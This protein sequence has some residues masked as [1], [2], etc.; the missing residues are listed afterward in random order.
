MQPVVPAPSV[1]SEPLPTLP[2]RSR[3]EAFTQALV[4]PTAREALIVIGTQ[5][6]L[7]SLIGVV[8]LRTAPATTSYVLPDG[9]NSMIVPAQNEH[10][11][12]GDGRLAVFT[13][14]VGLVIGAVAWFW[15]GLRRL[16]GPSALLLL[17]V[18]SFAGALAAQLVGQ[19][20]SHGAETGALRTAIKPPLHLHAQSV[21]LI[22]A[23]AAVLV[24]TMIAG[25]S[26]DEGLGVD[27]SAAAEPGPEVLGAHGDGVQG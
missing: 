13:A 1:P 10:W 7:G 20:L 15:P 24:Y 11:I 5:V 2:R 6:V 21:V 19:L 17:M 18:G 12:A 23:F 16:R 25:L 14:L 8:W 9:P 27:R 22:W 26:S 4:R 3:L